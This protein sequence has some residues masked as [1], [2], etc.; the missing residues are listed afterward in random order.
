MLLTFNEREKGNFW[1]GCILFQVT[2]NQKDK[3]R[4]MQVSY[5]FTFPGVKR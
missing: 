1:K 3:V 2:D 5:K 4:G